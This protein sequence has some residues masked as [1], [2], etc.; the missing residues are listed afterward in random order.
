MAD[1]KTIHIKKQELKEVKIGKK[2]DGKEIVMDIKIEKDSQ[3]AN[4]DKLE[5]GQLSND[6]IEINFKLPK[7]IDF[8]GDKSEKPSDKTLS[9]DKH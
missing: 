5:K 7:D 1:K 8:G 9:T 3:D 2:E 4:F 6:M